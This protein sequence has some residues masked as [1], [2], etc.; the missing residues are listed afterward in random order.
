MRDEDG[1]DLSCPLFRCV[2]D[3]HES[4]N[5]I[6]QGDLMISETKQV[7]RVAMALDVCRALIW[8]DYP[9]KNFAIEE[10]NTLEDCRMKV[11]TKTLPYNQEFSDWK[12]I[13]K[14]RNLKPTIF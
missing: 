6:A 8:H 12:N 2:V 4:W 3:R 10:T 11:G 1:P 13:S 9:P 7:A 5:G 14:S